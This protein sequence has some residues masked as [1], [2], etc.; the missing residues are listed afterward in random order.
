M[1]EIIF[2]D[3][4][5]LLVR[6]LIVEFQNKQ[7]RNRALNRINLSLK[8][9]EVLGLVG[10]S[11]SGKSV[12]AKTL[13]R[14]EYPAKIVC[15]SI[16]LDGEE[17]T[18]KRQRDMRQYRG[19]KILLM[20]QNPGSSMDPVFTIGK[21]FEEIISSYEVSS[22][23]RSRKKA[24]DL[25]KIYE[26]LRTM[27]IAS[28]EERCRQYPHE[29]SRGMLQRVLLVMA[30]YISPQVLILD[31][32]TSALDPTITLQ[33]LDLIARFKEAQNTAII[34]ITHD[35]SIASEVC[36]SIAVMQNGRI[37]EIGTIDNIFN[38]PIHP[39]TNS[40]VSNIF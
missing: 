4:Y 10:E 20:L 39:Y 8:P 23:H 14:L 40:L 21:Q 34:L 25:S 32:V 27:G 7:K 13:V 28:P 11:G 37:V 38:K 9:G 30:L 3:N 12:F 35:L 22:I 2:D 33:V 16:L 5:I 31:E 15:G 29:W 36:D 19:K 6:D 17:L 1:N 18:T 24:A 26:L